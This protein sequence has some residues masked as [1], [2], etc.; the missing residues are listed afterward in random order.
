MGKL[1]VI[2][3]KIMSAI[4]DEMFEAVWA[5]NTSRVNELLKRPDVDV[6]ARDESESTLLH[7]AARRGHMVIL[8]ALLSSGANLHTVDKY[9]TDALEYAVSNGHTEVVKKLLESGANPNV[10][11]NGGAGSPEN[12]LFIAATNGYCEAVRLLIEHGANPNAPWKSMPPL[13]MAAYSGHYETVGL[14]LRAGVDTGCKDVEGQTALDAAAA[15]GHSRV[16]ELLQ[17]YQSGGSHQAS[18]EGIVFDHFSAK[19]D[20]LVGLN[21][22]KT[23][24]T[25]LVN[26]LRFQKLRKDKGLSVPEQSLHMV[27]TGNPG[28]GKTTIA[29]LIAQIYKSMGLLSKGQFIE[30]D[31]AGLVGGYL[32]QTAIKTQEVVESALGGVLFIDEAYSLTDST[33]GHDMYGQEAVATC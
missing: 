30:T 8:S 2:G 6:N 25:Q 7:E 29:R 21:S 31:R 24:V 17:D 14:L 20:A 11:E 22:V 5:G 32:G 15:Q 33:H 28:T 3:V 12:A 13:I 27:F 18:N 19:L 23:D 10:G 16:V 26:Y 9:K 4:D 1:F